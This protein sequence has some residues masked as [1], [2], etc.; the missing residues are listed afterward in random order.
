MAGF[1][2]GYQ[3]VPSETFAFSQP[4]EPPVVTLDPIFGVQDKSRGRLGL[5]DF[6][7]P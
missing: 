6:H 5:R 3:W 2:S 1:V 4:H 7:S